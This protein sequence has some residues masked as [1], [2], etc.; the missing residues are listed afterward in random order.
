MKK[1]TRRLCSLILTLVLA[2]SMMVGTATTASAADTFNLTPDI[3][4]DNVKMGKADLCVSDADTGELEVYVQTYRQLSGIFPK[5]KDYNVSASGPYDLIYW[6]DRLGYSY[7]YN[8]STLYFWTDGDVLH[9]PDDQ[10]ADKGEVPATIYVNGVRTNASVFVETKVKDPKAYIY[11]P[12]VD[13]PKLFPKETEGLIFV[14]GVEKSSLA[15]WCERYG[16]TLT[17]YD[18][19]VF[20]NNN[21]ETPVVVTLNGTRMD[22]PYYGGTVISPGYTMLPVAAIARYFGCE[23]IWEPEYGSRVSIKRDNFWLALWLNNST[24]W[25]NG[26]YKTGDVAPFARNGTTLVPV[27]IL[28]NELG[29]DVSWRIS[30]GVCLVD[31]KS[32]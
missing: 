20:V 2:L 17:I 27:R 30:N 7:S 31:I 21:K 22:F 11:V 15:D 32:K 18:N 29:Y 14:Q 1:Q 13:I 19:I 9:L 5:V 4:V 25:I 3:Y 16:Y 6:A 28:T 26:S 12:S 10:V 8:I 23:V 24:Y